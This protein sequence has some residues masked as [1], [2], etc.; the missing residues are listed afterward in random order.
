[1]LQARLKI[2]HL[3]KPLA[4]FHIAALFGRL[5]AAY[6]ANLYVLAAVG[7]G[8]KKRNRLFHNPL[9][10]STNHR[11]DI[12]QAV[13]QEIKS[14]FNAFNI[15]CW[16]LLFYCYFFLRQEYTSGEAVPD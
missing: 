16:R 15:L 11:V 5:L 7:A 1:M 14:L 3:I 12:I 13:V 2:S 9:G 6:N 8:Y 4:A 10:N